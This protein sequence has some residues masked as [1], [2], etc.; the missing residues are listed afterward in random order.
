MKHKTKEAPMAGT[1]DASEIGRQTD[2]II[3]R[4]L[5]GDKL[6]AWQNSGQYRL[7]C[8]ISEKY[9]RRCDDVIARQ[10][11][12]RRNEILE[13]IRD[14]VDDADIIVLGAALDLFAKV[15]GYRNDSQMDPGEFI[16]CLLATINQ[17]ENLFEECP[18]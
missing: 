11:H 1:V 16:G 17:D 3:A 2:P 10:R 4:P 8:L 12:K 7:G 14:E 13:R 5:T 15:Y 18:F 6:A 9:D